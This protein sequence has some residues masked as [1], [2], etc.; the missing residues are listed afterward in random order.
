MQGD[1]GGQVTCPLVPLLVE[2]NDIN[3]LVAKDILE[4]VGIQVTIRGEN[5]P[6]PDH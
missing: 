1:T 5:V 3:Q 4:Q 2:D 6:L